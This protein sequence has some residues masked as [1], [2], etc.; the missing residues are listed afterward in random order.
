[1]P[2]KQRLKQF[3]Q[4]CSYDSFLSIP[5]YGFSIARTSPEILYKPNVIILVNEKI[6][7]YSSIH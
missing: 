6:N 4:L 5:A 1:M 7:K 2:H 3:R